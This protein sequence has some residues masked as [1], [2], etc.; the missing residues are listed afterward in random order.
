MGFDV[1]QRRFQHLHRSIPT[2]G[3]MAG[4]CILGHAACDLQ[5]SA[6]HTAP[7]VNVYLV[8]LIPNRF[9]IC[10]MNVKLP[11]YLTATETQLTLQH[12]LLLACFMGARCWLAGHPGNRLGDGLP[13]S[14]VYPQ[15]R[16]GGTTTRQYVLRYLCPG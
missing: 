1:A 10:V 4:Q 11:E 6:V 13:Q 3:A 15:C 16:A 5:P 14:A 7:P 12:C 2:S 9:S 8:K